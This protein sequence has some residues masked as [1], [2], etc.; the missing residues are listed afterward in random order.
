MFAYRQED[1][2]VAICSKQT[3]IPEGAVQAEVAEVPSRL[4]RS[5]WVIMAGAVVTNLPL[6]KLIAHDKRRAK[7]ELSFAPHDTIIAKQIPGQ[8]AAQAEV[9]R[10]GIR[11]D[12]AILQTAIEGTTTETELLELYESAAL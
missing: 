1:N 11:T 6:A 4:H 12:D 2:T 7:R 8:N 9:A 3:S 5:A 10:K